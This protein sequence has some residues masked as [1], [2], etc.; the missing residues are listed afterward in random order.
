MMRNAMGRLDVLTLALFTFGGAIALADDKVH[1]GPDPQNVRASTPEIPVTAERFGLPAFNRRISEPG[2]RFE[3]KATADS[4]PQQLLFKAGVEGSVVPPLGGD[5]GLITIQLD[6]GN[7]IQFVHT[8]EQLVKDGQRVHADTWVGKTGDKV[9][10]GEPGVAI[11]LKVRAL[12]NKDDPVAANEQQ[13]TVGRALSEGTRNA[14]RGISGTPVPGSNGSAV[15]GSAASRNPVGTSRA[16]FVLPSQSQPGDHA[17]ETPSQSTDPIGPKPSH[18]NN[19]GNGNVQDGTPPTGNGDGGA[20]PPSG[21]SDGPPQTPFKVPVIGN[22]AGK[23]SNKEV[24]QTAPQDNPKPDAGRPGGATGPKRFWTKNSDG[25]FSQVTRQAYP[26]GTVKKAK[27]IMALVPPREK[28]GPDIERQLAD[29]LGDPEDAQRLFRTMLDSKPVKAI[30]AAKTLDNPPTIEDWN[31][32]PYVSN[33]VPPDRAASRTPSVIYDPNDPAIRKRSD[34]MR[35]LDRQLIDGY[36]KDYPGRF[37]RDPDGRVWLIPDGGSDSDGGNSPTGTDPSQ[38]GP[39]PASNPPDNGPAPDKANIGY[40]NTP[41]KNVSKLPP[42]KLP[43]W[44]YDENA[45]VTKVPGSGI[46]KDSIDPNKDPLNMKNLRPDLFKNKKPGAKKNSPS[47]K[48]QAGPKKPRS[49]K[50]SATT[51]KPKSKKDSMTAKKSASKKG[52]ASVKKPNSKNNGPSNKAR[53]I[54]GKNGANGPSTARDN[55]KNKSGK[56]KDAKAVA[57]R[58]NSDGRTRAS[59]RGKGSSR[60]ARNGATGSPSNRNPGSVGRSAG[61]RTSGN[62][63]TSTGFNQPSSRSGP[64]AR[65]SAAG[66]NGPRRPSTGASGSFTRGPARSNVGRTASGS[67]GGAPSVVRSGNG[68]RSSGS[69]PM[70]AA[71]PRGGVAMPLTQNPHQVQHQDASPDLKNKILGND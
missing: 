11:Q 62:G 32:A 12:D 26:E 49:K 20:Q 5:W 44:S 52:P 48:N 46:P 30:D 35:E 60:V 7:K 6:H 19:L 38:S 27:D 28:P 61:S 59:A 45:P 69:F 36:I 56:N 29:A 23:D 64:A 42:P 10:R 25:D 70:T 39:T 63:R 68:G 15:P 43:W 71:R 9:P 18:T 37:R 34:E 21:N 14:A 47:E 2:I 16:T 1:T 66:S 58:K 3:S 57:T 22:G 24:P 65:T 31:L 33:P 41:D 8:S 4:P 54:A 51:K 50:D 17:V 53:G 55:P 40:D 13:S 67:G